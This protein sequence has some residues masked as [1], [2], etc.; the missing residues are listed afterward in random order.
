MENNIS[1]FGRL[2]AVDVQDRLTRRNPVILT[3]YIL[4]GLMRGRRQKKSSRK[5]HIK[6]FALEKTI[7]P[8]YT[9]P[10]PVIW[11]LPR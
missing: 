7:S 10:T 2:N 5:L 1:V 11:Y 3:C 9:I 8:M 6:S 4:N